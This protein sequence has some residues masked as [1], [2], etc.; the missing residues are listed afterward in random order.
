[1]ERSK[2]EIHCY[3]LK[4]RWWGRRFDIYF[5]VWLR[6]FV[7]LHFTVFKFSQG[8]LSRRL[9]FT[10]WL[11]EWCSLKQRCLPAG[12]QECARAAERKQTCVWDVL[13]SVRK[14]GVSPAWKLQRSQNARGSRESR[15]QTHLGLLKC[16]EQIHP[17][18]S[19]R[20]LDIAWLTKLPKFYEV[21]S[22]LFWIG[23]I[24]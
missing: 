2:F 16:W 22:T 19:G 14:W 1:M 7:K 12:R 11:R 17:Q 4:T 8:T 24:S 23:Y 20:H 21:M 15:T 6:W 18:C 5:Y 10:L 3:L 13:S 9:Y